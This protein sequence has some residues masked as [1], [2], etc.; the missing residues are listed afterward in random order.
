MIWKDNFTVSLY[1]GKPRN[2]G[3]I[4]VKVNSCFSFKAS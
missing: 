4:P 3:W 2:R 1:A